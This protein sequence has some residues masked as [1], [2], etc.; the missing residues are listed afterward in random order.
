MPIDS[1]SLFINTSAIPLFP[2][3]AL[4]SLCQLTLTPLIDDEALQP[5][6][7]DLDVDTLVTNFLPW[8]ACTTSIEDN[9]KLSLLIE[10]LLRLFVQDPNIKYESS[11]DDFAALKEAVEKG[12]EARESKNTS[13]KRRKRSKSASN[14]DDSAKFWLQCS[15]E[16]MRL[17]M[18]VYEKKLLKARLD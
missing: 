13:G 2:S 9:A 15:S 7:D 16:R 1:L 17:L 14:A 6:S 11:L 12:I 18:P 10:T 5:K 8:A 3:N 4:S